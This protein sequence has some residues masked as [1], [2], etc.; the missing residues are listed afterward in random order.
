MIKRKIGIVAKKLNHS[1][2]PLIHNYWS[3]KNNHNFIYR[4]YE[5]QEKNLYKFFSKY[6][7]DKQFVGF[8]ITIP[9]KE[10]FISFC[11]KVTNRAKKIGSVNLIYKK[12]KI[13]LGDNTDVIG[14][15][16][17]FYS[18]KNKNTKSVLLV[19]AGGAA[20]AILYFLN[21]KNIEN[22]DIFATSKRREESLKKNF[23]FNRFLIKS[24][25]LKKRYDLIINA[26]SAGMTKKNKINRNILNLVKRARGVID[27][28]YNPINTDL[29]KK[30]EKHEIKFS[31]GLKMLVEQAKPSYEKW[32]GNKIE[33]DR[34]IYQMLINK[35]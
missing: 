18:L 11:D 5:V 22:I 3:K 7:R 30:A 27:I 15:S 33:I 6:R 29:L 4:K 31:G 21:K 1:L 32:C 17:I 13:I 34:K 24:S 26:S 8:N 35:I 9:Y 14:F 16:K 20:R 2:S 25:H 23:K 10:N 19:G 28:V 12:D